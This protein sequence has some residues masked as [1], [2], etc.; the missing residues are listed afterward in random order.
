[1][2][3]NAVLI[4]LII[5]LNIYFQAFCIPTTWTIVVLSICFTNTIVY[6]IV[7]KTNFAPLASF[8]SGITLIVFIYCAIFLEG[9]NM[10]GLMLSFVGVGLVVFIPHFLGA[11][12]IWKYLIRPTNKKSRN[13]FLL[14]VC[15]CSFVV[16]YIGKEY[17]SAIRSIE[18]FKESN[19]KELDKTFMTEKI[20]GMHFIYH[21][22]FCEYDGWRPPKH[23][24]ILVIG[25][26]LN[27]RYDPLDVDLWTR[28]ELYKRFFPNNVYKFDCSCGIE[29]SQSYFN[30]DLWK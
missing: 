19:Y 3:L 2:V 13:I 26:W 25:M 29:Y 4:A 21:T 22:R 8:I 1:M 27:N 14:A 30:D 20:L 9:M 10:Y 15:I 6:P 16:I 24:P 17:K 23:E 18:S 28:L 11:Q 5:G 12:L 7:E